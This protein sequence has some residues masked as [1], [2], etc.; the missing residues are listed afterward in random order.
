MRELCERLAGSFDGG[1]DTI[2]SKGIERSQIFGDRDEIVECCAL[3]DYFQ[4]GGSRRFLTA[5][6][7][8]QSIASL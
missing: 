2:G 1:D 8:S 7:R 4:G 6:A 3:P 5:T